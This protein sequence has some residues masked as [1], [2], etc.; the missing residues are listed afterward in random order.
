MGATVTKEGAK[1]IFDQCNKNITTDRGTDLQL[2]LYTNTGD[3]ATLR[4]TALASITEPT[5]G[6]YARKTLTDAS[7]DNSVDYI[8]SYAKQTFTATGGA[9]TG[10]IHGFFIATTGTTPRLKEIIE[11]GTTA[12][13]GI[14]LAEGS[15]VSYTPKEIFVSP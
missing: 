1:I 14:V 2:G 6:G 3:L 9:M 7:W 11:F 4:A 15:S 5:G 8:S 12:P 10:T 13:S